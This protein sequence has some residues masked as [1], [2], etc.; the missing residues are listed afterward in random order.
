MILDFDNVSKAFDF[1]AETR[2]GAAAIDYLNEALE[3]FRSRINVPLNDAE[4]RYVCE[5]LV[6]QRVLR[7]EVREPEPLDVRGFDTSQLGLIN[8]LQT[9][10]TR[11][12]PGG[13]DRGTPA[14]NRVLAHGFTLRA[15]IQV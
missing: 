9:G 1:L 11:L 10:I 4:F 12:G 6:A 5:R 2:D 8:P 13:V 15:N 14:L 7:E 3:T